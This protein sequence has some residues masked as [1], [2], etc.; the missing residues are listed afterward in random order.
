MAVGPSFMAM[1]IL[2][3][4]HAI[5]APLV[6][7]MLSWAYHRKFAYTSPLQTALSWVLSIIVLDAGLVAPVFQASFEMFRSFLGTWLVFLLIF[8][9][10]YL[11]G[12]LAGR[13]RTT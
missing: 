12:R 9:T 4:V 6:S 7:G 11:A 3:V 13:A 10:T 1:P 5:V 8:L 2:L